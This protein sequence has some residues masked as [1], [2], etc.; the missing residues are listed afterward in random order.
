MA[1]SGG[2]TPN[3]VY[4]LLA[5]RHREAVPW[6]EIDVFWGD[7]RHVPPTHRESN[8]R[9]AYEAMLSRVPV[10]A[11]RVHRIRGELPDA[12]DAAADYQRVLVG[13]FALDAGEAPRF[14]LVLLGLGADG[15]TASLFPGSDALLDQRLVCAPWVERLQADRITL[16]LRVL[17]HAAD[18]LFVVSG[19]AKAAV[20]REVLE[21][22]GSTGRLP[23]QLIQPTAG[24]VTWMVD[25]AAAARLSGAMGVTP[26]PA[27]PSAA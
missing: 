9:A 6:H 2:T 5:S 12:Q 14:D 21:D 4:D 20:L 24:A 16:S 8:Y 11:T 26:G 15:H 13:A 17:N 7:E 27:G 22:D 10:A 25:R 19:E 1:L 23:A 18:V 3:V